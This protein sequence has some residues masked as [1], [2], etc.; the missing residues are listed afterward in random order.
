MPLAM[1]ALLGPAG[2]QEPPSSLPA[3]SDTCTECGTIID[4]QEISS[5]REVAKLLP[6]RAPPVGP[7]LS[8]SFGD[9]SP[10][11]P[12][13][14]VIGSQRMRDRLTEHHYEVTIRFDNGS[15]TMMELRD[16]SGLSEG[17]RIRVQA[18]RIELDDSDLP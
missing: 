7:V 8:F 17:D 12:H 6:E 1:L 5:E 15:Y 16:V 4:I 14:G 18:G 3:A 10:T 2:A 9:G 11:K 13:V